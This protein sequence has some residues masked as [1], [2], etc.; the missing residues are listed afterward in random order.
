MN[1][2]VPPVV[3][4]ALFLAGSASAEIKKVTH[5]YKKVGDLEIKAD[6]IREDDKQARPVVVWLH[7]GALIMGNRES[8]P[9]WLSAAAR[10]Q[11]WVLVSLDYRLAPETQLPEIICDLEDGFAWINKQGP[12]LF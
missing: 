9:Q 10:E 2:L 12:E 7:G 4:C 1:K 8:V 6:V 5:T 3:L 11:G